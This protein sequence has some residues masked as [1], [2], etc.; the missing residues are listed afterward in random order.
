MIWQGVRWNEVPPG[1]S[2]PDALSPKLRCDGGPAN[3]RIWHAAVSHSRCPCGL[4]LRCQICDLPLEIADLPLK[5]ISFCRVLRRERRRC[6]HRLRFRQFLQRAESQVHERF[7][8]SS[9]PPRIRLTLCRGP[10]SRVGER[11]DQRP[12]AVWFLAPAPVP[13][14]RPD[15]RLRRQ[16]G[17]SAGSESGTLPGVGS[18]G[19]S[20]NAAG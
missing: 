17:C 7:P 9:G 10:G 20:G 4:K 12:V 5:P 1:G 6:L 3:G 13:L 11:P 16:A 18:G 2:E 19:A 15:D 8:R 14:L